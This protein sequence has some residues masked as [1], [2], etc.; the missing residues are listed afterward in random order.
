MLETEETNN[1]S[2][3]TKNVFL[4]Y[5]NLRIPHVEYL[6]GGAF[7]NGA[8]APSP[9]AATQSLTSKVKDDADDYVDDTADDPSDGDEDADNAPDARIETEPQIFEVPVGSDV[10]L[11]CNVVNAEAAAIIWSR[12]RLPNNT[13]F[14]EREKL[15]DDPRLS[16]LPNRTLLIK[17]V[18]LNDSS[19]EY[20]CKVDDDNKIAHDLRVKLPACNK[21]AHDVQ[22]EHNGV[23]VTPAAC[24]EIMQGE[25]IELG[26]EISP[27]IKAKNIIWTR[28]GVN[29]LPDRQ[30][31]T[32]RYITIRNASR[33][34]AG[35]Y[36]CAVDT[37]EKKLRLQHLTLHV[38]H[39]DI[40]YEKEQINGHWHHKDHYATALGVTVNITC[41][42]H[43]HP[44]VNKKMT[45]FHN[46][47]KINID[48][49]RI[50]LNDEIKNHKVLTIRD[51]NKD[52]L[53]EYQCH[54]TNE[55]RDATGPI[56]QLVDTPAKPIYN[57]AEND[58]DSVVL[59]W[60]V[61]SYKPIV[62]SELRFRQQNDSEW[63]VA[64]DVKVINS[65][66]K[67]HIV[68][69]TIRG[70]HAG[71]HEAQLRTRN[72]DESDANDVTKDAKSWGPYS[73]PQT[74]GGDIVIQTAGVHTT[75]AAMRPAGTLILLAVTPIVY[76]FL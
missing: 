22:M 52:D 8:A 68:Q 49:R 26:C 64:E 17:N 56:I 16:I 75:G 72:G 9:S 4:Y 60:K 55:D 32:G 65:D 51:V 62:E 58:D 18:Q 21:G 41:I 39:L 37:G 48:N 5:I 47:N 10:Y 71:K 74:F 67:E 28:K 46:G 6:L 3:E 25:T 23:R 36:V 59:Q 38:R 66:G 29:I 20:I 35:D 13:L 50:T 2:R 1:R 54:A 24:N 70:I 53:G 44:G 57:N 45:W 11:P 63:R 43:A 19:D 14:I 69:G 7:S 12:G 15:T 61:I 34:V 42:V 30:T 73:E 27:Q 33:H 40:E 76:L 31:E